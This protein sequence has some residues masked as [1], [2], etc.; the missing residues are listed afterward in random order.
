MT[1]SR[2]ENIAHLVEPYTAFAAYDPLKLAD[3]II[4]LDPQPLEGELITF[5]QEQIVG[6]IP[7][8]A[9]IDYDRAKLVLGE[10]AKAQATHD[11][12]RY[13]KEKEMDKDRNQ[14]DKK[15]FTNPLE[16]DA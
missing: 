14:I 3:Q 2:R 8:Q 1:E 7:A 6:L 16:A 9:I 13:Q 4:A 5:T 15:R 11:K 12:Q 10:V